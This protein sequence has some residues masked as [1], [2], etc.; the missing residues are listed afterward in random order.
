M[1]SAEKCAVIE[2]P[3]LPYRL[4]PPLS[5]LSVKQGQTKAVLN[6]GRV[7]TTVTSQSAVLLPLTSLELSMTNTSFPSYLH[8]K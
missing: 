6:T 7:Y 3:R 2:A 8:L 1:T 5:F 4:E